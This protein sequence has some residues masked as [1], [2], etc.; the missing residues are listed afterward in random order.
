VAAYVRNAY[1]WHA[2]FATAGV[3]MFIGL[4]IFIAY[5][6]LYA[7]VDT[8]PRAAGPRESLRALW[9][10]CMIP[11]VVLCAA[12]FILVQ[13][14]GTGPDGAKSL[15]GFNGPTFA[16]LFACIPVVAF[17]VRTWASIQEP[18]ARGRVGA[19][20]AIF[21]VVIIFWAIF[22]QNGT[23]LTDW[24]VENTDR[25]ANAAIQVVTT[26][27]PEFAEDAHVGYFD[28][29]GPDTPRPPRDAFRIVTQ[30]E[31]DTLKKEKK[32][33]VAEGEKI[34]VT[35][36]VFDEIYDDT[37]AN[38]RT[39][40]PG[41]KLK[42]VNAELFQSINPGLVILFTPLLVAFWGWLGRQ[43]REP[44]T[45]A[46]IGIGLVLTACG[47]LVML[48]ASLATHDG[49]PDEVKASAW[50]LFGAYVMLTLGELCLSPMGLSLVSKMAPANMRSLMMGG[51]F[52]ST[53]IGNKL[54]GIFGEM[55]TEWDHPK[56]YMLLIVCVLVAAGAVF[57]MLP[58]LKQQLPV[59]DPGH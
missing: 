2:A 44:S 43:R 16:F 8:D 54:S 20:L 52:M 46:K 12:G 15:Y 1:G 45:P 37:N 40:A 27:M 4:C 10:E 24:A 3:G 19:L 35:Q 41:E 21:G 11:A 39:L 42:L 14:V 59:D 5:Y 17:F 28:N 22:H 36:P 29:A 48:F 55:Y 25:R 56:F 26:R 9:V 31:Y 38:T 50:W 49:A 57:M 32:L 47:P 34:P 58:W 18:I 6:K 7:E 51:W 30:E 53:A 23:A 33:S 13:Q